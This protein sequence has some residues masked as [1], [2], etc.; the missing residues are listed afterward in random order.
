MPRRVR[1][2]PGPGKAIRI[3]RGRWFLR[4]T[5]II[6]RARRAPVIDE[7]LGQRVRALLA[8]T[9]TGASTHQESGA[10]SE[11]VEV[12]SVASDAVYVHTR[13][14]AAARADARRAAR[15]AANGTSVSDQVALDLKP[16]LPKVDRPRMVAAKDVDEVPKPHESAG[17]DKSSADSLSKEQR[18]QKLRIDAS[19]V[20]SSRAVAGKKAMEILDSAGKGKNKGKAVGKGLF[21]PTLLGVRTWKEVTFDEGEDKLGFDVRSSGANTCPT[22][23]SMDPGS[24]AAAVAEDGHRLL[25][26][27]GLDTSM[28]SEGQVRELLHGTRP[29]HLRFGP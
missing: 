27:S 25:R 26:V 10:D 19:L 8:A 1:L 13:D 3:S 28:L 4:L 11:R 15:E 2:N 7:K 14:G 22:V 20:Q 17:T 21:R 18:R 6:G 23:R 16:G 29:L 24:K 12:G 9:T 5:R